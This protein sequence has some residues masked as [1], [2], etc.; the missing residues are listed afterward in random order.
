MK[1]GKTDRKGLF[2]NSSWG[3]VWEQKAR[4]GRPAGIETHGLSYLHS[5]G[6]ELKGDFPQRSC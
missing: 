6:T 1:T 5:L 4:D 3:P 2:G